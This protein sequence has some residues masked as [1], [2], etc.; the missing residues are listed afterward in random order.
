MG[1]SVSSAGSDP[2]PRPVS[3]AAMPVADALPVDVLHEGV[4]VGAR[5]GAEVEVVGVLVHVERQDGMPPAS[6]WV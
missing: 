5:L 3:D 1:T 6:V 4:D 2:G